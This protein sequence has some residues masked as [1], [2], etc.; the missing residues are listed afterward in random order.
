MSD[1]PEW[2]RDAQDGEMRIRMQC[3]LCGVV[4]EG[5]ALLAP[6]VREDMVKLIREHPDDAL[7]AVRVA[8]HFAAGWVQIPLTDGGLVDVCRDC[9]TSSP[10]LHAGSD[11]EL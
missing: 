6:Q 3:N 10:W 4:E 2:L 5:R 1:V 7:E 8:V 11:M 9:R